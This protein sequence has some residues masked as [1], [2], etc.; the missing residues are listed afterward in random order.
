HSHA[1]IQ[2]T[3]YITMTTKDIKE[4]IGDYNIFLRILLRHLRESGINV[5]SLVSDHLCYRVSSQEIYQTKKSEFL[6][7]NHTLLAETMVNGRLIC[8]FKLSQPLVYH[9]TVT[10]TT[11]TIELVELPSPKPN[12]PQLDGLEHTEF[13]ID[14]DFQKFIERHR[15]VM[16]GQ[17]VLQA[18]N[19]ELNADVETEFEPSHLMAERRTFSAK[20]HHQTLEKVIEI[21]K[22]MELEQHN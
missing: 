15:D 13:V 19:K 17:W 14:E 2:I 3:T 12:R 8:T 1:D 16:R 9:D 10:G 4:I 20:F 21:E 5:D 22:A 6:S 18:L 7:N 11:R